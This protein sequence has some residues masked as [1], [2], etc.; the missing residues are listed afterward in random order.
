MKN[1]SI[2]L[3]GLEDYNPLAAVPYYEVSPHSLLTIILFSQI[4]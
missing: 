2:S 3:P 4:S 1:I